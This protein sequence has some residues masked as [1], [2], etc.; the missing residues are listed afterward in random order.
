VRRDHAVDRHLRRL[1]QDAAAGAAAGG[2]VAAAATAR[3]DD[4]GRADLDLAERDDLERA[5]AGA[6]AFTAAARTTEQRDQRR[7]AVRRAAP[8]AFDAGV[9]RHARAATTATAEARATRRFEAAD[10]AQ[11]T[12]ARAVAAGEAACI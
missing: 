11:L 9:I 6:A 2:A 5:A 10:H 8:D 1:E 3:V 12:G 7:I 4:T